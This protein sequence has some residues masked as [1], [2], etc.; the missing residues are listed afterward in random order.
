MDASWSPLPLQTKII[1]H[2]LK[3]EVRIFVFTVFFFFF[4]QINLQSLH[5]KTW[6]LR[7]WYLLW[8]AVGFQ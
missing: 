2:S 4:G 3:G 5:S 7:F 6:D 8:F 1:D